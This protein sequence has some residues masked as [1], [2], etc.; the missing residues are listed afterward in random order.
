MS[1][2]QATRLSFFKKLE[3]DR[4][5]ISLVSADTDIAEQEKSVIW[6]VGQ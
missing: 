2:K 3:P 1:N 4:Y 5:G 6:Y